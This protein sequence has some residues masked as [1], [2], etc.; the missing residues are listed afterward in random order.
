MRSMATRRR[1]PCR[2]CTAKAWVLRHINHQQIVMRPVSD[3][4]NS[5]HIGVSKYNVDAD[6][7]NYEHGELES[8]A[9]VEAQ[10]LGDKYTSHPV[11]SFEDKVVVNAGVEL[12]DLAE[13]VRDRLKELSSGPQKEAFSSPELVRDMLRCV[14]M[15]DSAILRIVLPF[16]HSASAKFHHPTDVC[17]MDVMPVSPTMCRWPRMIGRQ[18]FEHPAT[19]IYSRVIKRAAALRQIAEYTRENNL[20]TPQG[21]P[22]TSG[23]GLLA[24][25]SQQVQQTENGSIGHNITPGLMTAERAAAAL[26]ASVIFLQAAVNAVFDVN[27]SVLPT[28]FEPRLR[29]SGDSVQLPGLRQRLEK[30]EGLFRMYMMGKRVNYACRSVISPDP[31]LRVFEVGVPLFIA[32]KLTFPEPV[33]AE[34]ISKLRKLVKAGPDVYPGAK[35]VQM[36]DGSKQ[37][38]PPGNSE[39]AFTRRLAISK[40]LAVPHPELHGGMPMVVHRHLED[41]DF[42]VMNRQPT[43]HKPSMQ[44][45]RVRT[46]RAPGAKTLRLHYAICKAYNADFDGDEMNGH[47]PQT[48]QAKAEMAHLAAVPYQYLTPKDGSPLGGLIQDHVIATV[49]LTIRD[50][51]FD[52]DEYLDLVYNGLY[53]SVAEDGCVPDAILLPPALLKPNRL[54]TGKQVVST[55]L[56]NI[57]P[58]GLP[59]LNAC[60][61]GRRTKVEL[62]A[63]APFAIARVLSDVDLVIVGG[64]VASGLLDKAH[65]GSASGGLVHCF[66]E[67]YGP[68]AASQLLSGIS[69][70]ADRF[71]K[72]TSFSMSLADIML[73]EKADKDRR[74]RFKGMQTLGLCAFADAFGLTADTL[75]EGNVKHLY[76]MAHF[77]PKT[78]EVFGGKMAALDCAVKDRI[79]HSQD[80]VCD[81][82]IPSGLYIP[83]PANAL[84][85]MVHVGAKGGIVNA[86]QMSVALGQ[87]ELEGRRVP[88]MLSGR[89][90]PSFPPYDVRPRAGGM[91]T[92]RFL[93]SMPAQELFF[94]SMAGRDGLIDTACKTSRSGYL[95]RSLIKHLEDLSVQYDGT[96]RDSGGS[97]I[98]FRYGDDGLDVCQSTFLKPEG[99][100]FFAENAELLAERWRCPLDPELYRKLTEQN[101]L[102]PE[103]ARKVDEVAVKRLTILQTSLSA[104]KLAHLKKRRDRAQRKLT[105]TASLSTLSEPPCTMAADLRTIVTAKITQG[106]VPPGEPVGLLAAQSVGE[107]STQMTLNT[108]H[109]AGRGEM[110][111]TLGIPRLREVLMSGSAVIATPCMEVPILPTSEAKSRAEHIAREMYRL[112]LT[113]VIKL[114]LSMEVDYSSDS[115]S[116]TFNLLPPSSYQSRTNVGARRIMHFFE[117]VLFVDLSKR[118]TQELKD[119]SKSSEIAT[120]NLKALA[121]QQQQQAEGMDGGDPNDERRTTG[122]D[123]WGEDDGAE[124]VRRRR[125]EAEDETG[126]E[127]AA[128]GGVNAACEAIDE[129]DDEVAELREIGVDLE[130]AAAASEDQEAAGGDDEIDSWQDV[131]GPSTSNAAAE[132]CPER[133][134]SVSKPVTEIGGAEVVELERG[135]ED[136]EDHGEE[137]VL[138][139]DVVEVTQSSAKGMDSR[140]INFVMSLHH[141]FTDYAYDTSET[142][143]WVKLTISM[144]DPKDGRISI[145]LRTLVQRIISKSVVSFVPNIRKAFIDKT[146]SKEWILRV[147]GENI[148]VLYRYGDVFDLSRLYTN[149]VPAMQAHFGI[150]A[151]RASLQREIS[152]VFSHYGISVNSRHLGLVADYL[153][154]TGAYRA[155]N[156][157]TMDFHPSPMQRITFETATNVLKS[158]IQENLVENTVSPSASLTAGQ[159][160]R[161]YGTTCFDLLS[162]L[163]I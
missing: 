13:S 41:G 89:S 122:R 134:T 69:R 78:D 50:C 158:V 45:H 70:V 46:I 135:E 88:L 95:Q 91:C 2:N 85:L 19:A 146:D 155:F 73:S 48:Y 149:H 6:D 132:P 3:I 108:F 98:Q 27:T 137:L 107:P 154:K 115:C 140:R 56:M 111:V 110:N 94:H 28:G 53:A 119:Q 142:P 58:V 118:L 143:S 51:F 147:E 138:D 36:A 43:L 113:E 22:K 31:N 21:L 160:T 52:E 128:E 103:L 60:L 84:Q 163:S 16:L 5:R 57:V 8:W 157:R 139:R 136:D 131:A 39:T 117:R 71:L 77:A 10:L 93:T 61:E 148:K 64:Y 26:Q 161:G 49:K 121:R 87:I 129:D 151:A 9:Q 127:R 23:G 25:Q 82:A 104:K 141:R 114:P 11:I 80:A 75:T 120:F 29:R 156:R 72:I 126:G 30:K 38:I 101:P 86:Q 4:R 130:A 40:R 76:R 83:F 150:E 153:T 159:L 152:S 65:I 102:S 66:Y 162:Q 47:F 105:E 144:F 112:R 37:I 79:K 42:L 109:F 24:K 67:A 90:L 124:A 15:Q 17:F 81:A 18:A 7:A 62:W 1:I 55:L 133:S 44:A 145:D 34:N 68:Y 123:E 97:V 59:Q 32:H 116:L 20:V 35:L 63:G 100:H 14:W 99:F 54:W 74:R 12:N 96:V 106:Q 92:H 125:L 33:T